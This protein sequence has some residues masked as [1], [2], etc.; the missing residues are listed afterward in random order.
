MAR[1]RSAKV[2]GRINIEEFADAV[3][4]E[5]DEFD[6]FISGVAIKEAVKETAK[7]TAEIVSGSA[8]RKTGAYAASITSGERKQSRGR[9]S[10]TVY[11]EAPG[12][13]L[14]HLLEKSHAL[15]NGGRSTPQPHWAKGER[16]LG[17]RFANN[18]RKA[19]GK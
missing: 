4:S 13:R 17:D 11:A 3:M 10:E 2:G 8:P 9:Y 12:Y 5:L 14:T 19:I 15:R 6:D 16:D 18:L 7:E 1:R